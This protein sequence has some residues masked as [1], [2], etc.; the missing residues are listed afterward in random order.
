L[1][2]SG[3]ILEQPTELIR[4]ATQAENQYAAGIGVR[5][6]PGDELAR[7]IEIAAELRTTE[8]RTATTTSSPAAMHSASGV[9]SGKTGVLMGRW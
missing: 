5:R 7:A 8:S 2:R 1:C 6:Q 3:N 9:D 4:F